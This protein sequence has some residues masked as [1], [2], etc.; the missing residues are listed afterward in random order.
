MII[1][2]K[3]SARQSSPKVVSEI[4]LE[5]ARHADE[6]AQLVL[7]VRDHGGDPDRINHCVAAHQGRMAQH[8]NRLSLAVLADGSGPVPMVGFREDDED[9]PPPVARTFP[10][11]IR[12]VR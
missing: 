2:K 1:I 8:I 10:E 12:G 3:N 4:E 9:R 5:W 11:K 6:I 7:D